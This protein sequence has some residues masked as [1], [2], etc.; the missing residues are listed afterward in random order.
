MEAEGSLTGVTVPDHM[1]DEMV[2]ELNALFLR[3]L[4]KYVVQN[5]S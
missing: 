2:R 5:I 3:D 1:F 4:N